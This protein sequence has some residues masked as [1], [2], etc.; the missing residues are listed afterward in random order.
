LALPALVTWLPWEA[1]F[2][3]GLALVLLGMAIGVP[4]G[5]LYH[6]RLYRLTRPTG[7]W[8]LRPTTL[9]P[10]LGEAERPRVMGVFKLGA[11]GFIIAIAGCALVAVGA[12]RSAFS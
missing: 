5:A 3:L 7:T 4:A 1:T 8:W 12:L 10:Q 6:V 9:H 11:T 2:G